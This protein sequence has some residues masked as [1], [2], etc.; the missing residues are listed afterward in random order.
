MPWQSEAELTA[1]IKRN[2]PQKEETTTQD[3]SEDIGNQGTLQHCLDDACSHDPG[4][5]LLASGVDELGPHLSLLFLQVVRS[6]VQASSPKLTVVL[7]GEVNFQDLVHGPGSAFENCAQQIFVQGYDKDEFA[8]VARIRGGAANLA[9]TPSDIDHLFEL[10]GGQQHLLSP[11]LSAWQ[12][13]N[14]NYT[15]NRDPINAKKTFFGQSDASQAHGLDLL[16]HAEY[17]IGQYPDEWARLENLIKGESPVAGF[18]RPGP[19]EF[20]GL[21]VRDADGRLRFCSP[22]VAQSVR[23]YFHD[24]RRGDWHA[25]VGRWTEALNAYERIEPALRLR[26]SG[27]DDRAVTWELIRNYGSYLYSL[28]SL[29]AQKAPQQRLRLRV[30]FQRG[31]QLLLGVHSVSFWRRRDV[32][33]HS[34]APMD[35]P[36]P[37]LAD[38]VTKFLPLRIPP[39]EVP[40]PLGWVSLSSPHDEEFMMAFIASER[41][42][43]PEALVISEAGT[44]HVLTRERKNLVRELGNVFLRAY[45]HLSSVART[46]TSAEQRRKFE[47]V[48][49]TALSGIDSQK[50]PVEILRAAGATLK[51]LGYKR[52]LFSLVD[53]TGSRIVGEVDISSNPAIDLAKETDYLVDRPDSDIQAWVVHHRQSKRVAEPLKEPGVNTKVVEAAN[54]GPFALV[55][56]L[57]QNGEALGTLHIER[58]DGSLPTREEV[59]DFMSFGRRLSIAIERSERVSLYQP[60]LQMLRDPVMIVDPLN[61]IRFANSAAHEE[62]GVREGW[63]EKREAVTTRHIFNG[64]ADELV[65]QLIATAHDMKQQSIRYLPNIGKR[66]RRMAVLAQP[67]EVESGGLAN[68]GKSGVL[69]HFRDHHY[70]WTGYDV[71]NRLNE[72]ITLTDYVNRLLELPKALGHRWARL[73]LCR[74]T[75]GDQSLP[76]SSGTCV[77]VGTKSYHADDPELDSLFLKGDEVRLIDGESTCAVSTN[78]V[79]IRKIVNSPDAPDEMHHGHPVRKFCNSL[80]STRFK[81]RADDLWI[82]LPLVG[83]AGTMIGLI[84]MD[85]GADFRSPYLEDLRQLAQIIASRLSV[86]IEKQWTS[87]ATSERVIARVSHNIS[88]R[89]ASVRFIVSRLRRYAR[90]H[91][92][93]HCL[94]DDLARLANRSLGA[95]QNIQKA[96]TVPPVKRK[97]ICLRWWLNQTVERLGRRDQVIVKKGAEITA[98]FDPQH[99]E[100]CLTELLQNCSDFARNNVASQITIDVG[101]R[102]EQQ[103]LVWITVADNGCGIPKAKRKIVF[104]D[105]YSYRPLGHPSTGLGLA[106]AKR[107]MEAHGGTIEAGGFAVEDGDDPESAGAVF[108]LTW[109]DGEASINDETT[110]SLTVSNST[111]SPP[112]T[113]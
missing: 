23:R 31:L 94:V 19:L 12:D 56:L 6:F 97:D 82:D 86:L 96:F 91:P 53:P 76:E 54:I 90:R 46:I 14:L 62:F 113:L 93:A 3:K 16:Q 40:S 58:E 109:P 104:D 99:L 51:P 4:L 7:T 85:L 24:R 47:E 44:G 59:D 18:N 112:S 26:P 102:E 71:L 107:M 55:P 98:H 9:P 8:E 25:H 63:Q 106:T 38:A 61:R 50:T 83:T 5:V 74:A 27:P 64:E 77:L 37:S 22:L 36:V 49:A 29:P 2:L 78:A 69:L 95:V 57:G 10:T 43:Q 41:D 81:L 73:W 42:D 28:A 20:A 66:K 111:L 88:T 35:Y 13:F 105:F 52:L 45:E 108:F 68:R 65:L 67:I 80:V 72:E 21:A 87:I 39:V 30:A 33:W 89:F 75:A 79:M 60:A 17:L 110:D 70:Q 48:A 103:R 84:S 92:D 15:P 100:I 11:L 34:I 1:F 32:R 101:V